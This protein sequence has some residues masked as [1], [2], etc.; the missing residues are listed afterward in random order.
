NLQIR[1]YVAIARDWRSAG[2]LRDR[3]G[4]VFG[5]PG[6]APQ[7]A[8]QISSAPGLATSP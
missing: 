2:R 8:G 1:E 5:P 4:Y 3:L 7:A 6:W